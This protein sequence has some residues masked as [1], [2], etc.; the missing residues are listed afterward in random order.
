MSCVYM[1]A[2]LLSSVAYESETKVFISD[3]WQE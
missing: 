3:R 2:F 1:H